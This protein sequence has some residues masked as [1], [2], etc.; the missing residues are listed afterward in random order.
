MAINDGDVSAA[1]DLPEL[2]ATLSGLKAVS[3]VTA[4]HAIEECRKCCGGQGFL[5]SSGIAKLSPDFTEWVTVEESKLYCHCSALASSLR[6]SIG[7]R[8]ANR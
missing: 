6:Q 3:T 5:M 8:N 7:L 4:H 2:H 1:D